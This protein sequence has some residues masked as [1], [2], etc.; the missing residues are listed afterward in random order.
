MG[1]SDEY[2]FSCM[3][4]GHPYVL[5]P[6]ETGYTNMMLKPCSEGCD[7]TMTVECENCHN[8]TKVYWCSGHFHIA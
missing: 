8:T 4:C 6:P 5:Y 2:K 1:K 3:N 7:K